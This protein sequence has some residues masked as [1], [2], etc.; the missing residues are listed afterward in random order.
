MELSSSVMSLD[1]EFYGK[2]SKTYKLTLIVRLVVSP[3]VLAVHVEVGAQEASVLVRDQYL[4][5][6]HA[7]LDVLGE[8][9]HLVAAE[10]VV[11]PHCVHVVV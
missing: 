10:V 9:G 11:V 1:L 2:H 7:I 6:V 5:A 4:S 8:Y 3:V